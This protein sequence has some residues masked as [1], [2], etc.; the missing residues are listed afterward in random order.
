MFLH[1]YYRPTFLAVLSYGSEVGHSQ[2][3]N[4]TAFYNYLSI[5]SSCFPSKRNVCGII[6]KK[7]LNKNKSCAD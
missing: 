4:V 2:G 6:I 1:V 7:F 3:S 5:V